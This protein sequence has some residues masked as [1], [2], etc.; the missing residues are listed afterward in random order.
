MCNK[1]SMQLDNSLWSFKAGNPCRVETPGAHGATLSLATHSGTGKR[2]MWHA[3]Y[4]MNY[5]SFLRSQNMN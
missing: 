1:N 3:L 5:G 2:G 4:H